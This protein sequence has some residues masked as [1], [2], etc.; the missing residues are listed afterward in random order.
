MNNEKVK[1]RSLKECKSPLS[2]EGHRQEVEACRDKVRASEAIL[3]FEMS[4][5][6]VRGYCRDRLTQAQYN[7]DGTKIAL[8]KAQENYVFVLENLDEEKNELL[9]RA[10]CEVS[11]QYVMIKELED[12]KTLITI[13][14]T[15]NYTFT[16]QRCIAIVKELQD[17][18]NCQT[19]KE[20]SAWKRDN[21]TV[22]HARGTR[23]VLRKAS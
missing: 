12:G 10:K 19:P 23:K 2:I 1:F 11:P 9:R 3:S 8:R 22:Y 16:R 4:Q 17:C 21:R 5:Q 18:K 14:G 7:L 13:G 20:E 15:F 6:G